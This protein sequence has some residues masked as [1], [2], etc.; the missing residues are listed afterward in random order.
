MR[1][2]KPINV[3]AIVKLARNFV[4]ATCDERRDYLPFFTYRL[5]SDPICIEHGLGDSH[6]VG[7]FLDTLSIM[8]KTFHMDVDCVYVEGLTRRLYAGLQ[9]GKDKGTGLYWN[10]PTGLQVDGAVTHNTREALLGLM[11]SAHLLGTDEAMKWAESL[12]NDV[13]KYA[14]GK[15]RFPGSLVTADGWM[16]ID[17]ALG[18]KESVKKD[19]SF[20][21]G[22]TQSGDPANTGRMVQALI[23]YYK[24]SSNVLALDLAY[25]F[26]VHN[27]STCF[28]PDG[29]WIIEK[30]GTH[31]HSITGTITAIIY[32]G[33][34]F[35]DDFLLTRGRAAFDYGSLPYRSSFGWV[36]EVL[37]RTHE[38]SEANNVGDILNSAILLAENVDPSYWDVAE[39]ILRNQLV[40][41][42]LTDPS[43]FV[44]AHDRSD[45]SD[46]VFN[47]VGERA[48]GGFFFA[49]PNDLRSFKYDLCPMN[50]DLVQGAVAALANAYNSAVTDDGQTVKINILIS[51]EGAAYN[52]TSNIPVSGHVELIVG[53]PRNVLLRVPAYVKHSGL[54]VAEKVSGRA[55][56]P[57]WVGPYMSLSRQPGRAHFI[58]DFEQEKK[59]EV[60]KVNNKDFTVDW[61][62]DTVVSMKAPERFFREL[63]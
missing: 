30:T 61:L 29:T 57:S 4:Y 1:E 12:V 39:K 21:D 51:K 63:Y 49:A 22:L 44:S 59:T 10:E 16:S 2:L 43:L 50:A 60:E 54:K 28:K 47:N 42:Q 33:I 7:R 36:P 5:F 18:G 15:G 56:K 19:L 11:A 24:Y 26:A 17:G 37:G 45:T 27:A 3:K 6:V 8:R 58:V 40:A 23:E 41:S 62:G 55:V 20:V 25:Q 52:F 9:I 34:Y 35:H 31:V 53:E 38:R 48:V 46:L 13:A 32:A 14:Y